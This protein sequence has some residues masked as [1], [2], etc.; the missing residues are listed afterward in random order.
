M[1]SSV[2]L[3]NERL[4]VRTNH[5][6]I[7]EKNERRIEFYSTFM[8]NYTG[9]ILVKKCMYMKLERIIWLQADKIFM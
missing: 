6:T 2:L 5:P 8:Y 3:V 1:F 7:S 9:R 4:C